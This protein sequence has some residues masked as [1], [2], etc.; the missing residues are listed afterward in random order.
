MARGAGFWEGIQGDPGA[1]AHPGPC[2]SQC[3]VQEHHSCPRGHACLTHR[4]ACLP[5]LSEEQI[6]EELVSLLPSLLFFL[7]PLL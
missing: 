1:R 2:M 5:D 4:S 3:V 7:F 6:T